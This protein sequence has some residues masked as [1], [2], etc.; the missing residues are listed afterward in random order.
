MDVLSVI[1]VGALTVPVVTIVMLA[2]HLGKLGWRRWQVKRGG[3]HYETSCL[4]LA[5]LTPWPQ[6]RNLYDP[7]DTTGYAARRKAEALVERVL[8]V[9]ASAS[10]YGSS[11]FVVKGGATGHSYRVLPRALFPIV[12]LTAG[13]MLCAKPYN[14][15][16]LPQADVMLTQALYLQCP[17]TERAFVAICNKTAAPSV[18]L[19]H[20]S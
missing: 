14:S 13:Q 5:R 19:T 15:W 11:G 7:F 16:S 8:G 17:Q 2:W 6:S 10:V 9:P 4:P 3:I 20:W 18:S 1:A 12:D